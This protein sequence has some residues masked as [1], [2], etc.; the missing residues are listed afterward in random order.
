MKSKM[1]FLA[2]FLCTA[3]SVFGQSWAKA[4]VEKSPRHM[5]WV[6]VTNGTRAVQ[7]WVVYPEVKDKATAVLVIHDSSGMTDWARLAADELAAAGYIAIVPDFFSGEGPNGG[8]TSSFASQSDVA[9]ARDKLPPAQITGDIN[10]AAEYV[11]GLPSANGKLAEVGF[12]WGGSQVSLSVCNRKDLQAAFVFYGWPPKPANGIM[13]I[14]CPVYGFYGENDARV[15]A[16]VPDGRTAMK[17]ADKKF[18]PIIYAG[19]GHG[20]MAHGEPEYPEATA[21]DRK[22]RD[23]AWERLKKLLKKI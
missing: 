4:Q 2:L 19:A 17:K 22:A 12:C 13:N 7:C 11:K 10:A 15:T 21:A 20:F 23:Q 1:F 9:L 18:E 14:K 16:T 3:V 5:D 8:G 6:T